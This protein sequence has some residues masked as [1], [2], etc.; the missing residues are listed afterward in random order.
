MDG[1][2]AS[3]N[4]ELKTEHK[5]EKKDVDKV[6]KKEEEFPEEAKKLFGI[7]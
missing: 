3:N 2:E 7:K 1:V 6:E 5:T 4:I